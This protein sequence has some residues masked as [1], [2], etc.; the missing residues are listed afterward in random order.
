MDVVSQFV[1]SWN[2]DT[3][4]RRYT[5]CYTRQQQVRST[6]SPISLLYVMAGPGRRPARRPS[7]ESSASLPAG[8]WWRPPT[9]STSDMS[10]P[11]TAST[12]SSSSS[13]IFALRTTSV[14]ANIMLIVRNV[15]DPDKIALPDSPQP[16]PV[17]IGNNPGFRALHLTGRNEFQFFVY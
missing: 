17:A 16:H 8:C 2:V 3:G 1:R 4:N 7:L 10:L 11:P 15:W 13:N 14:N 9:T 5:S 6:F 12:T